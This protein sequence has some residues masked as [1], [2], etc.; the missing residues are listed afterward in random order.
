MIESHITSPNEIVAI[1]GT[2]ERC[3]QDANMA[4]EQ[5]LSPDAQFNLAY[6]AAKQCAKLSLAVSGY[7]VSVRDGN[8][9]WLIQSLK[10]TIQ[11]GSDTVDLLD[12]FRKKR[13][14]AEYELA[15]SISKIEAA[16]ILELAVKLFDRTFAWLKEHHP[17]LLQDSE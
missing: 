1:T 6:T 15:G 12:F 8:H 2:I 9:Y 16:E 11:L 5:G 13:N 14:K 10:H 17:D 3:L 4:K 7:R